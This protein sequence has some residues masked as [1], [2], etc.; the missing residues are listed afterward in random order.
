[1]L[2]VLCCVVESWSF[3]LFLEKIEE[4]QEAK[5]EKLEEIVYV[6]ERVRIQ[7]AFHKEPEK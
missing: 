5:K 1:M 2:R 3:E 7:V 6:S 4:V